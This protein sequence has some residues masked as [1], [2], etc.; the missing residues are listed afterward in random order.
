M[1]VSG[2]VAELELGPHQAVVG[3]AG[4]LRL[5]TVPDLRRV[6]GKLLIDPGWVLVDL[7]GLR[8]QW[9]DAVRAF[10]AALTQSGGWPAARL[11]L[12]GADPAMRAGLAALRVS[13]TVPLC[14]DRAAAERQLLLRPP[15]VHRECDLPAEHTA[16][17]V[18]RRFVHETCLAWEVE[19]L[20]T[21]AATVVTEL[22]A[23]AVEHA[24]GP[25]RLGLRQDHRGLWIDVRDYRLTGPPRPRPRALGSRR[26]RG[27]HLVAAVADRWGVTDHRD[28]KTVWALLPTSTD[29]REPLDPPPAVRVPA[30]PAAGTSGVTPRR[31]DRLP[32]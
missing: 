22:V 25:S 24:D 2:L 29:A 10:P 9:P 18:A 12:F 17:G 11:V 21:D 32:R 26:G 8:L 28:G 3:L 31:A 20:Y 16:A 5:G 23:N 30:A 1:V 6:L 7:S 19:D 14:P 15:G 13:R 27:L 4:E